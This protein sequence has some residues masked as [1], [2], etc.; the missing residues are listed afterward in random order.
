MPIN[1]DSGDSLSPQE[2]TQFEGG[3]RILAKIIARV[4]IREQR[5]LK[6]DLLQRNAELPLPSSNNLPPEKLTL[7]VSEVSKLLG[8]SRSAVYEAIRQGQ[9]PSIRFG[10][11]ILVPRIRLEMLLSE[12]VSSR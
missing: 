3:L 6:S 7:S 9:I 10:K 5:A 1:P 8:M 2:L 12:N 11:R 4:Y